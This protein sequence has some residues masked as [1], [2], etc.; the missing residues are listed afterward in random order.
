MPLHMWFG[1]PSTS[2]MRI[3]SHPVPSQQD[4]EGTAMKAA[5]LSSI[6]MACKES[7]TLPLKKPK[8]VY[9]QQ[10][11]GRIMKRWER[12]FGCLLNTLT[13]AFAVCWIPHFLSRHF[14]K[15]LLGIRH[16]KPFPCYAGTEVVYSL[17]GHCGPKKCSV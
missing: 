12:C 1:S 6:T 17:Y 11:Y 4:T 3:S 16:M 10:L 2:A 13:P 5:L 14:N 7:F 8:T 9:E 15:T